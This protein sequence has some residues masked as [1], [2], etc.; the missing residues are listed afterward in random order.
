MCVGVVEKFDVWL[1]VI[2]FFGRMCKRIVLWFI[3]TVFWEKVQFFFGVGFLDLGLVYIL[4]VIMVYDVG[5]VIRVEL[6]FYF[7]VGYWKISLFLDR[8]KVLIC[9]YSYILVY[10]NC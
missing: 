7:G 4:Y 8:F 1:E 6:Q 5:M 3:I 9:L 10:E 2:F